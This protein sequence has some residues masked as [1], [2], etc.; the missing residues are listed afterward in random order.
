M[1]HV[2]VNGVHVIDVSCL[3]ASTVLGEMSY[4]SAVKARAFG[5]FGSIVLLYQYFH[6]IAVLGLGEIGVC[7]VVLVLAS[8]IGGP[9]AGQIHGYLHIVI[10]WARGIGR[11]VDGSLL[12]LLWSWLVL[13]ASSPCTWSELVLALILPLIVVIPSWVWQSSSGSDEFN[14]LSSLCDIDGSGFVFVV[15]LG[16]WNLDDFVENARG[17]S[18]EEEPNGFLVA[19]RV[20]CLAY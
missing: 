6:H 20:A 8:V 1:S 5:S 14:H 2:F 12:L 19:N 9:G 15:V 17:E 7:V 10:G 3:S 13:R 4:F 16:E 11:I 18:I